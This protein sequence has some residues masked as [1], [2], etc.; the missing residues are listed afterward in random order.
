VPRA[1]VTFSRP[2]T[3]CCV[4]NCAP[5]DVIAHTADRVTDAVSQIA[6][7]ASHRAHGTLKAVL[8]R[9]PVG[10]RDDG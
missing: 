6:R 4:W 9:D 1:D 7:H 2:P 5:R 10:K 3:R 8:S